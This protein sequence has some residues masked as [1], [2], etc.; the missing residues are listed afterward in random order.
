M[1]VVS[2]STVVENIYKNF[3]DLVNAITDFDEIVYPAFPYVVIDDKS[4]YP[5]VI[6]N[7][8]EVSWETFTFGTSL[9]EGTIS[10]E[11]YTTSAKTTD[12]YTSDV[13]NQIE[14]SKRTLAT[15]NLRQVNLES[16][17]TASA[18]HGKI[19][20]HMKTL[21]FNFKFYFTSTPAW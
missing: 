3:Y 11:I 18:S 6:I 2:K 10:I 5:I 17:D 4:D 7:S 21:T 14:I 13:S 12:Q 20:V 9:L 16:T 8:P 19:R 1:V 15:N